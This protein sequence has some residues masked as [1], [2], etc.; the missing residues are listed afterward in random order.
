VKL[1]QQ[2]L[3]V[4]S[5]PLLGLPQV[6]HIIK[7]KT[8]QK[9]YKFLHWRWSQFLLPV[10]WFSSGSLKQQSCDWLRTAWTQI[11]VSYQFILLLTKFAC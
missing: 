8:L 6:Q 5:R 9:Q 1:G 4:K 7:A 2:S 11:L 3:P 10:F